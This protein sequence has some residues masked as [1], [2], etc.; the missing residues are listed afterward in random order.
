MSQTRGRIS[1]LGPLRHIGTGIVLLKR[2]KETR[3]MSPNLLWT[4]G[5]TLQFLTL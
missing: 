1:R 3:Q 2:V 4:Y 5:V